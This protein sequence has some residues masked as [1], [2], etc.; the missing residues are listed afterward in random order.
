MEQFRKQTAI[1]AVL[2]VLI[3]C[4]AWYAKK[5]NDQTKGVSKITETTKKVN[6]TTNY[7]VEARNSRDNQLSA[8]KQELQNII[9]SKNSTKQAIAEA[10]AKL[11]LLADWADKQARVEQLAKQ[12]GF[13]DAVCFINENGV[14]LCVKSAEALTSEQ[15]AQL[16]DDVVR[17]T[18]ISPTKIII[19]TQK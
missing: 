2:V 12:R 8:H 19:K 5:F 18:S 1:I 9:N 3:A 11:I 6:E 14:E 17:T 4:S 16:M 7:F 15:A 13:E 10:Q